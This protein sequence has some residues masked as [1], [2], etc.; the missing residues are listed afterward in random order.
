MQIPIIDLGGRDHGQAE[1]GD[2]CPVGGVELSDDFSSELD[3]ATVGERGLFDPAAGPISR[4][5]DENVGASGE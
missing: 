2:Q 3:Q 1:F 5:E 4:L